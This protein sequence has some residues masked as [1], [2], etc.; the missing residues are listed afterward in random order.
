MVWFLHILVDRAQLTTSLFSCVTS[1]GS[2]LE[3]QPIY[4]IF[5]WKGGQHHPTPLHN[6]TPISE[7]H[8]AAEFDQ[9]FWN[10]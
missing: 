4:L 1:L 6:P 5:L 7:R 9:N 2:T 8:F 3:K 10:A